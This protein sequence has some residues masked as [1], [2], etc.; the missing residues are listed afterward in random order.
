MRCPLLSELPSPPAGKTGWPWTEE[1]PQ[2]SPIMFDGVPWPKI[3]IVTP[4]YN[5]AAFIEETIRSVLLQGYPDLE[6]IVIDAGSTD[7]SLD[8]IGKY[9]S[10][11]S[12]WVSESDNGQSHA[13]NKGWNKATGDILTWINSD[14]LYEKNAFK[15]VAEFFGKQDNSD[16]VYG[17]CK[18]IDGNGNFI[19]NSP[20]MPFSL[21]ALVCNKWFISQPATF[22]KKRV[23]ESI[24]GL[25]E[26]LQLVMDWELWLR[27][28]LNGYSIYYYPK[29]VAKYRLW[30]DAKTESLSDRSGEEK[31]AVLN[32]IF[33]NSNFYPTIKA[34]KNPAYSY[35]HR[36]TGA[37][38]YRVKN[39]QKT[40]SHL[41]KSI[42]YQP[43]LIRD[44]KLTRMILF[45]LRD[46]LFGKKRQKL[47]S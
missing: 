23:L 14:D 16:M 22:V 2:A 36:W 3:S 18:V 26:E 40:I 24:G 41:M 15:M 45:S 8:V 38:N 29:P 31:I 6:Y 9:E 35:V 28:A 11:F 42:R 33:E 7:G 12:Y 17:N 5:Q 27:I 46:I 37:A 32:K 34:Y 19:K 13:I 25:D 43:S 10:W 20:V 1:S 47:Y 44:K 21:E 39:P 30:S 4:S